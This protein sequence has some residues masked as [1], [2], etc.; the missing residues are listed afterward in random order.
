[1]H[2]VLFE[3]GGLPIGTNAL[4][5]ML[6]LA[7]GVALLAVLAGRAGHSRLLFAELA[8]WA[9]VI[10][11]VVSKLVGLA[12]ELDVD[13]PG[14]SAMA[15][16]RRAGY[17]WAGAVAALAFFVVAF[18]RAKVRLRESLD[19]LAPPS[20]LAWGLARIGTFFAGT[21]WGTPTSLP[22]AVTYPPR[23]GTS[24]PP[25]DVAVH[26]VQLYESV[27]ELALCGFLLWKL[28]KAPWRAGSTMLAYVAL[29]ATSRSVLDYF[30]ADPRAFLGM[31]SPRALH[32]IAAVAAVAVLGWWA[33]EDS[34]RRRPTTR[35]AKGAARRAVASPATTS[36][37]E[38]VAAASAGASR[39]AAGART[40]RRKKRRS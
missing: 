7:A 36:P 28:T 30:R 8:L 14:P 17:W 29:T 38:P 10:G 37:S 19:L 4:F 6:A 25:T 2:P 22:W 32:A 33:L 5:A 1:M 20:A 12:V 24:G 35:A 18:G 40:G 16:L 9:F 15:V 23:G 34:K 21:G 13:R 39:S 31:E 26:P 11:L 27:V 3:L